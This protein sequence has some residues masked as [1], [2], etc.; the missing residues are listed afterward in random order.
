MM[1]QLVHVCVALVV[2]TFVSNN[3]RAQVQL[4]TYDDGQGN[5]IDYQ[6][7]LPD[8]HDE[9]DRQLPLIVWLHGA[10]GGPAN[11]PPELV[12]ATRSG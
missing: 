6:V 4:R 12:A 2:C 10:G 11:V 8:G 3:L 5:Q 7:W 1:K 9:P